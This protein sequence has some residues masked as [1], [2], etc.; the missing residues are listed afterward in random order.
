MS[1]LEDE[2][3]LWETLTQLVRQTKESLSFAGPFLGPAF[4]GSLIRV[5][6]GRYRKKPVSYLLRLIVISTLCGGFLTPL[7]MHVFSLPVEIAG[8]TAVFLGITGNDS[9][10]GL[11]TWARKRFGMDEAATHVEEGQNEHS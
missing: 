5:F 9:V 3:I 10:D 7:A 8:A 6:S 1:P 4:V 11:A 2:P